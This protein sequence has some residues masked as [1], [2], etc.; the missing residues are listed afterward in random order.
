MTDGFLLIDKPAG[1]PSNDVLTR[2]KKKISDG[3]MVRQAHHGA[4]SPCPPKV[5]HTGTLDPFATGLLVVAIGEGVKFISYLN[6]EPKVYEAILKLGVR[7]DTMDLTGQVIETGPSDVIASPDETSG[8]GD[9]D[10][11]TGLLRYARNDVMS[12]LRDLL[13]ESDQIPPMFSA[14]KQKGKKLYELAR[15]GIEVERKPVKVTIN[16]I[17]VIEVSPPL[18]TFRVSCSRGT[19]VRS[20]G[21][22]IA[23]KLGT[24]GHLV[25]LRR[26]RAGPF[27]VREAVTVDGLWNIDSVVVPI[28]KGLAHLPTVE[29]GVDEAAKIF[30]GQPISRPSSVPENLPLLLMQ[31]R[32]ALGIGEFRNGQLWPKRLV[33]LGLIGLGS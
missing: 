5:G 20:L 28:E 9:P 14:K 32:R 33:Q 22:T 11:P 27:D 4:G 31:N 12:L 29:L 3:S 26:L 10:G 7:T 2:L 30:K 1:I 21:E 23:E 24:V 17:E 25:S 13:G 16:S 19:Y 6:E 8:R 15:E 18:L